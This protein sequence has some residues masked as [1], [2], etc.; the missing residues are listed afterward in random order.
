MAFLS[1]LSIIQVVQEKRLATGL[2]ASSFSLVVS[3]NFALSDRPIITATSLA[4]AA[5][6]RQF[7]LAL[8]DECASQGKLQTWK[9]RGLGYLYTMHQILLAAELPQEPIRQRGLSKIRIDT[10]YDGTV[11]RTDCHLLMIWILP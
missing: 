5:E 9:L 7:V 6:A 10:V 11:V 3:D 4:V 2:E 1:A 8:R